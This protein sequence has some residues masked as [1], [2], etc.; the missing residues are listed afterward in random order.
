MDIQGQDCSTEEKCCQVGK[1]EK[2]KK[3]NSIDRA[4]LYELALVP[5][6]SC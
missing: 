5:P 4:I 3:L 1:K 6:R 2:K